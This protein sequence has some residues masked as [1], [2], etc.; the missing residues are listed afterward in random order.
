MDHFQYQ[1]LRDILKVESARLKEFADKYREVKVQTSRKKIVNTQYAMA[2][3]TGVMNRMFMGTKSP[4]R[5]RSQEAREAR[6]FPNT[7]RYDS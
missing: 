1:T 6:I 2:Q 5:R 7:R 4:S 3:G